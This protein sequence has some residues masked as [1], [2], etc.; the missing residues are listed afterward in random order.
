MAKHNPITTSIYKHILESFPLTLI[1]V[2]DMDLRVIGAFND[3]KLKENGY[4]T[5]DMIG[6]TIDEIY[7]AEIVSQYKIFWEDA[8]TGLANSFRH[9]IKPTNSINKN[10]V[11]QITFLPIKNDKGKIMGG[12]V[13]AKDITS[14]HLLQE[15]VKEQKE[16]IYQEKEKVYQQSW[17]AAHKLNGPWATIQ[18][19]LNLIDLRKEDL[20]ED[21][22]ALFDKIKP[23]MTRLRDAIQAINDLHE[24][25]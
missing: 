13:V 16:E 4:I 12:M 1:I 24:E 18:G 5:K 15:E 23:T 17:L 14:E 10:S 11:W 25:D 7:P 2:Y 6:K 22:V 8:I 19:V 9:N 21:I 3:K 20:P